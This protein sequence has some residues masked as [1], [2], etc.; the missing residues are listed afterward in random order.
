MQLSTR[1]SVESVL[2]DINKVCLPLLHPCTH[3]AY[4]ELQ[5]ML[6]GIPVDKLACSILLEGLMQGVEACARQTH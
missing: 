5:Q 6:S 2:Q 4:P 3:L 1:D